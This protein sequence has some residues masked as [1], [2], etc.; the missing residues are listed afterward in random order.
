[1]R[2]NEVELMLQKLSEYISRYMKRGPIALSRLVM[3]DGEQ[4]MVHYKDKRTNTK[5]TMTIPLE[6]FIQKLIRQIPDHHFKTIQRYWDKQG[7]IYLSQL[8]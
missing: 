8:Y 7:D 2:R 1:M 4:V 5:E 6:E 3:Y